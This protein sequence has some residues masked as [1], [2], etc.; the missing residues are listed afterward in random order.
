[1]K[2]EEAI[3]M[4]SDTKVYVDGKSEEIQNK[5]FELGFYWENYGKKRFCTDKPFLYIN[6]NLTIEYG[7]DMACFKD[8]EFKE[9]KADDILSITIDEEYE[10]K[11]FDKVLVRDHVN[12]EWRADF[13]SHTVTDSD[14]Y[15]FKAIS[16]CWR[17]CIPFE[18]NEHLI[19]TCDSPDKDMPC[20]Y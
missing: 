14:G 9:I 15:V 3:K 20:Q 18:G 8:N 11:P 17:Q 10:F 2:K 16:A 6:R 13:F 7:S 5:L 19:G 12:A 1:M 4:V